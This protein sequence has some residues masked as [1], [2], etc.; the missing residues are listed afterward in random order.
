MPKNISSGNSSGLPFKNLSIF[1]QKSISFSICFSNTNPYA[2][3]NI[4]RLLTIEKIRICFVFTLIFSRPSPTIPHLPDSP[5]PLEYDLS[6]RLFSFELSSLQ[7]KTS[8]FQRSKIKSFNPWRN[9]WKPGV[10][11]YEEWFWII[12]SYWMKDSPLG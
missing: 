8:R 11:L 7:R 10:L 9:S 3:T 5:F 6:R 2:N 12:D 4:W 1:F